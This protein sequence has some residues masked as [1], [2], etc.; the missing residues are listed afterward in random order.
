HFC[1]MLGGR[2]TVDSAPG[3]GSTFTL[4]LPVRSPSAAA[5]EAA[6]PVA[7]APSGDAP[8]VMVID[9]DPHARDLLAEAIRR[10][11]YRVMTVA[12]ATAALSLAREHRPDLVTLDILMPRIDGWA[13]LAAFKAD[14]ELGDTPVIIVTVLAE[15]GIALSL[16]AAGFLTKPV[17]RAR[18]AALLRQNLA[19]GGT[20]LVV[21]DER[22]S[23]R[24]M[25][26]HLDRLGCTVVEAADGAAA[27]AWLDRHPRPAMILLDLIMPGM[28]G[29]AFLEEI[30]KRAAWRDVPIVV[31]TAK[32]L[33]AAEREKLA[34]RTREVLVK[35]ADDL[36]AALKRNLPRGVPGRTVVAAG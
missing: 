32:Q 9:D 26:R 25:R 5:I 8:L 2:I 33:G 27:L 13:L 3:K 16:G 15:R 20:I 19:S 21:D 6:L 30:G 29:F 35:G 22:E 7:G 28:D 4:V 12:D 11:G 1:E 36:A 18:L 34:G 10:E 23:R 14:A 24:L 31:V 17:D